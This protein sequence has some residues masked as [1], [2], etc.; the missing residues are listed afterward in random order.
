[1]KRPSSDDCDLFLPWKVNG[2]HRRMIPWPWLPHYYYY[3]YHH[4][5][6]WGAFPPVHHESVSETKK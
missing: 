6:P 1:M 5:H 4:H 3:Y 2:E